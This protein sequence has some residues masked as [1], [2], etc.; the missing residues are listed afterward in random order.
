MTFKQGLMEGGRTCATILGIAIALGGCTKACSK[1]EPTEPA[2][3]TPIVSQEPKL[4]YLH[5]SAFDGLLLRVTEN[6][7]FKREINFQDYGFDGKLDYVKIYQPSTKESMITN[8]TE[9]TKWQPIFEELRER[10]FGSY[11]NSLDYKME[12]VN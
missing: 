3:T 11:T 10:R 6:Q 8:A 4:P 1:P 9:L 2:D 12:F 5:H 7:G